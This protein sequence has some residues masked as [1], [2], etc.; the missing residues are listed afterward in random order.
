[1]EGGSYTYQLYL[2]ESFLRIFNKYI[3]CTLCIYLHAKA[4]CLTILFSLL[5]ILICAC[6]YPKGFLIIIF[7]KNYF[8]YA[9]TP[10]TIL[11]NTVVAINGQLLYVVVQVQTKSFVDTTTEGV[12]K[13]IFESIQHIIVATYLVSTLQL[14]LGVELD[15]L[16][17]FCGSDLENCNYIHPLENRKFPIVVGRD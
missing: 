7:V 10:W 15:V 4:F 3:L 8:L 14:K 13:L 6:I 9:Y 16:G 11:R 1:M 17:K 12:K 5:D 2:L